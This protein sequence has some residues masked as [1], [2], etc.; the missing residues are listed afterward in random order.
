[1]VGPE[2]LELIVNL[3][4]SLSNT[5]Y[6]QIVTV[7]ATVESAGFDWM[8]LDIYRLDGRLLERRQFQRPL[9]HRIQLRTMHGLFNFRHAVVYELHVRHCGDI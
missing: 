5:Q 8:G 9:D 2:G 6:A 4:N 1:M 3:L 7:K